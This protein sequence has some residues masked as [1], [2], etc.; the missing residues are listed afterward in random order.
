MQDET[1]RTHDALMAKAR[2]KQKEEQDDIDEA[3]GASIMKTAPIKF[4]TFDITK[5]YGRV[6][7]EKYGQRVFAHHKQLPHETLGPFA[8]AA[9]IESFVPHQVR[10]GGP[11]MI[12]VRWDDGH[13]PKLV[14]AKH[15]WERPLALSVAPLSITVAA[16]GNRQGSSNSDNTKNVGM[17]TSGGRSSGEG[18]SQKAML[19]T[20][21]DFKELQHKYQK[22]K[23]RIVVMNTGEQQLLE[24]IRVLRDANDI[25]DVLLVDS[26]TA[27]G[28][29]NE[30]NLQLLARILV[31]E[32][33]A[34]DAQKAQQYAEQKLRQLSNHKSHLA[35]HTGFTMSSLAYAEHHDHPHKR[36]REGAA[37]GGS[38]YVPA[39]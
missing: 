35:R 2:A 25:A 5:D 24:R 3:I 31:L 39:Q 22:V 7:R 9:T 12:M 33:A 36:D 8:W 32:K 38:S 37:G 13:G 17:S 18:D 20:H 10:G 23:E 15:V 11:D 21:C 14:N 28:R 26:D 4:P 16:S 1:S 30:C 6:G 34:S 29:A 27:L 19:G